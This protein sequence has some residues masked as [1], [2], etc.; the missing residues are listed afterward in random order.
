MVT[1]LRGGTG[2]QSLVAQAEHPALRLPLP[3]GGGPLPERLR[4]VRGLH[5]HAQPAALLAATRIDELA[6]VIGPRDRPR[7]HAHH[8]RIQEK[9]QIP[10]MLSKVAG[11]AGAGVSGEPGALIAADGINV[12]LQLPLQPRVRAGGGSPGHGLHGRSR[13]RAGGRHTLLRPHPRG[14]EPSPRPHAGVPVQPPRSREP[15]LLRNHPTPPSSRSRRRITPSWRRPCRRC[16]RASRS[17]PSTITRGSPSR[18]RCPATSS[19]RC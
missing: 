7:A 10:S 2:T 11:L 18:G 13:L 19:G 1:G 9:T 3:R 8:A 6:G 5:L 15:D 12:A 16:R 14:E 4:G 17:S